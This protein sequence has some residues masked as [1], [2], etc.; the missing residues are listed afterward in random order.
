MDISS[1]FRVLILA[2]FLI[3][4]FLRA[5]TPKVSLTLDELRKLRHVAAHR[6]R[7]I[8]ANNDGCDCLYYPK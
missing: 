2:S 3:S 7:G 6:R 8:I 1:V 5:Q 4:P